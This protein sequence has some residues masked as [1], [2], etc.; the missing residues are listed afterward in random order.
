MA[1]DNPAK[2]TENLFGSI[3]QFLYSFASEYFYVPT[4]I[5]ALLTFALYTQ[6]QYGNMTD[7]TT[8][9]LIGLSCFIVLIANIVWYAKYMTCDKKTGTDKCQ[10][11]ANGPVSSIGSDDNSFKKLQ[12]KFPSDTE[13][14]LCIF[15][16]IVSAIGTFYSIRI[17]MD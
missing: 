14:F 12:F 2:A 10:F 9:T 7:S 3:V 17:I 15:N 5:M 16:I 1:D 11:D 4:I 8:F 13:S 6:T